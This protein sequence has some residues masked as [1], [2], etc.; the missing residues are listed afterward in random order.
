MVIRDIRGV[1][2]IVVKAIATAIKVPAT[3]VTNLPTV[4][5]ETAFR[6]DEVTYTSV[7]IAF[8]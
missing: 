1:P 3:H 5:V 4:R 2:N 6:E 7:K 8:P